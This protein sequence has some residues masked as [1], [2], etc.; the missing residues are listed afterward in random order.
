MK[1][2]KKPVSIEAVKYERA[3]VKKLKCFYDKL[4]YNPH[5]D[6][7]YVETPKGH[8]KVEDGDFIIKSVNGDF[9]PCKADIFYETYEPDIDKT[10]VENEDEKVKQMIEGLQGEARELLKVMVES[11]SKGKLSKQETNGVGNEKEN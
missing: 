8:M 7:Y 10:E 2:R 1:Y 3:N 4:K 11:R 5:N 6:D 9:Y